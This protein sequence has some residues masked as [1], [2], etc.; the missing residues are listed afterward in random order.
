METLW[1]SDG[2]VME[3]RWES[4]GKVMEGVMEK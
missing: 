1:K 3:Q 2:K 4:Y